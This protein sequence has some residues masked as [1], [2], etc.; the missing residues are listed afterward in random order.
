[1]KLSVPCHR[2]RRCSPETMMDEVTRNLRGIRNGRGDDDSA[3]RGRGIRM[4]RAGTIRAQTGECIERR[5][6]ETL[7]KIVLQCL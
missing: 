6:P 5:Y 4:N 3:S 7:I 1:M 2:I